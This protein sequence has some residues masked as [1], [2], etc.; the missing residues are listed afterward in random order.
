MSPMRL[1]CVMKKK[2]INV[3]IKIKEQGL[4]QPFIVLRGAF[5]NHVCEILDHLLQ[6]STVT[7]AGGKSESVLEAVV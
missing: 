2:I 3:R 4:F 7:L 5:E 1:C 6:N